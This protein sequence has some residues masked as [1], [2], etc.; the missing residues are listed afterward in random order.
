MTAVTPNHTYLASSCAL[1]AH[2][3]QDQPA[4]YIRTGDLAYDPAEITLHPLR[5]H[6]LN[7]DDPFLLMDNGDYML[8]SF[9]AA[10]VIRIESQQ[11]N[12]LCLF[13]PVIK[14]SLPRRQVNWML[15]SPINDSLIPLPVPRTWQYCRP[16]RKPVRFLS[17]RRQSS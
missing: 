17:S 5:S 10:V 14:S 2:H 3:L 6:S 1:C 4:A 11:I 13:S 16:I 7:R 8:P 15:K 12:T 9:T